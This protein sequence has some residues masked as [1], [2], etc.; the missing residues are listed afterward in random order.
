MFRYF[1]FPKSFAD[2][3]YMSQVQQAM[4]IRTAVEG[5]RSIK[6]HCMGSLYWQLNDTWP[7]A[8]W[9]SL[10]HGG[11]WKAL[12]YFARRFFSPVAVFAIPTRDGGIDLFASNDTRWG[13]ELSLDAEHVSLDGAMSQL[14]ST[15]VTVPPDR[16]INVLSL[17][18]GS[19]EA[20][21]ILAFRWQAS[22]GMTGED[23]FSPQRYKRLPLQ[24][25]EL[26]LAVQ[27]MGAD[28]SVKIAARKPAFFVSLESNAPGR[29][30]DNFITV[31]PGRPK[32][33][34]FV[35]LSGE[36]SR[37]ADI[38]VRDLHSATC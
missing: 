19:V 37:P 38:T 28:L 13:I 29:F 14:A 18:A 36:S 24:S 23:H 16:A 27:P 22:N 7:V 2:F 8:S 17:E 34:R 10:D 25:P 12:H 21:A 3:V 35:P 32:N 15:S 6:P 20:D 11:G 30:S 1:R 4:A 9:S 31:L 26:S 33:V 5:W